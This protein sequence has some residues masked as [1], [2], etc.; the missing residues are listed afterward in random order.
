MIILWSKLEPQFGIGTPNWWWFPLLSDRSRKNRGCALKTD[1][2]Q[3]EFLGL[4]TSL[5]GPGVFHPR[6]G[7]HRIRKFQGWLFLVYPQVPRQK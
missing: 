2:S 6:G 3:L 4:R 7:N 1:T 5:W